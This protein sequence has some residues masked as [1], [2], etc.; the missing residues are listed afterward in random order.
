MVLAEK[1]SMPRDCEPKPKVRPQAK[2]GLKYLQGAALI[3]ALF[4]FG[5]FYTYKHTEIIALGYEIESVKQNI[6]TLQGENKRLELEIARLQTPERVEKI[7][8]TKLGMEEPEKIL[9]AALPPEANP[10]P[11]RTGETSRVAAQDQEKGWKKTLFL[12]AHH[13]IGRAE[14][15]PR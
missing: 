7:A 6:A 11:N 2:P 1:K 12:A 4:I 15:S 14:A 13:F 3:L 5:L 8:R 9:L 10:E